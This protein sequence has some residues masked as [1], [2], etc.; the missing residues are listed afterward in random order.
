MIVQAAIKINTMIAVC[1]GFVRAISTEFL[2]V[3]RRVF[4]DRAFSANT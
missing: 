4:S 2:I 1:A 3:W